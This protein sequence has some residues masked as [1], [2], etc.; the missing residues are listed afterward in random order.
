M[1]KWD[2]HTKADNDIL[3]NG[4]PRGYQ[5]VVWDSECMEANNKMFA[6]DEL[7]HEKSFKNQPM[8]RSKVE[9]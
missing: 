8:R 9:F 5:L 7:H 2:M 6:F 3:E 1:I 4:L